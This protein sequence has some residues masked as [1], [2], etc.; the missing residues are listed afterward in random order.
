MKLKDVIE[1]TWILK[2]L[3]KRGILAQY[4]KCKTMLLSGHFTNVDFKK[5]QPKKD[6]IYYFRINQKYRAICFV[7][8]NR[9]T[10]VKIDSHQ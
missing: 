8:D 7:K 6:N 2:D 5:R 10:V 1:E 9:L 3:K 4:N